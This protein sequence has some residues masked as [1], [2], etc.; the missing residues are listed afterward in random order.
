MH[1][2]SQRPVIADRRPQRLPDC[3]H[4]AADLLL[5]RLRLPHRPRHHHPVQRDQ[6]RRH[7]RGPR[8]RI[9]P[10]RPREHHPKPSTAQACPTRRPASPTPRTTSCAGPP[11]GSTPPTAHHPISATSYGYDDAGNLTSSSDSALRRVQPARP[12]RPDHPTGRR[13]V[14]NPLARRTACEP[15]APHDVGR[16]PLGVGGGGHA[17][18]LAGGP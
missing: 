4:G 16:T 14:H 8:L 10:R 9:Q 2:A 3:V 13:P 7:E 5:L 18:A 11:P 15:P 17:V 1:S 6:P 12:D